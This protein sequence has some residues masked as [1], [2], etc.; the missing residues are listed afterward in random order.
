[1]RGR[2]NLTANVRM[3]RSGRA[4]HRRRRAGPGGRF[5]TDACIV[6]AIR[7]AVAKRDG[8]LSGVHPVDLAAHVLRELI[9]RTR[10]DPA[11]VE[12]V[13]MGCVS[14]IGPQSFDIARNAWLSVG[15]PENVRGV[16]MDRQRGSSQQAVHFAAQ[17]VLP[18]TQDLVIAVGALRARVI[19]APLRL[20]AWPSL[21]S[22]PWLGRRCCAGSGA[23]AHSACMPASKE[24]TV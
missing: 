11:A 8:G 12:D 7:S 18:G 2:L 13:I 1:V 5:I 10:V 14:Q 22:R 19:P 17:A 16:T 9:A 15:P 20:V 6:G 4:A 21:S 24:Y 3:R 23:P